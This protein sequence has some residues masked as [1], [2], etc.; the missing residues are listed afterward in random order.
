MS[1]DRSTFQ[2]AWPIDQGRERDVLPALQEVAE[3]P[4]AKA[5]AVA[6]AY[7]AIPHADNWLDDFSTSPVVEAATLVR[8]IDGMVLDS[9]GDG[10]ISVPESLAR[11]VAAKPDGAVLSALA[12]LKDPRGRELAAWACALREDASPIQERLL[13]D[14][15]PEVRRAAAWAVIEQSH[16]DGGARLWELAGNPDS[17]VREAIAE[18]TRYYE[19][20]V[21]DALRSW[22]GSSDWERRETA[23]VALGF[24]QDAGDVLESLA[25][26]PLLRIKRIAAESLLQRPEGVA[27]I[28]RMACSLNTNERYTAAVA[29]GSM[30]HHL[31]T[32]EGMARDEDPVVQDAVAD[33]LAHHPDG[34]EAIR[35]LGQSSN[36]DD[37]AVASMAE[38]KRI[39]Y[40]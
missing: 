33:S 24:R 12:Q 16:L 8:R 21:Q 20:G 19:V 7:E 10:P 4:F 32:L 28:E 17:R 35:R 25:R 34:G 6:P 23:T 22:A 14:R 26:D 3:A 2:P 5:K 38:M 15:A 18:S 11:Q 13:R 27:V 36:P 29:L 1:P 40:L 37:Q 39:E 31:G 9:P 30:K